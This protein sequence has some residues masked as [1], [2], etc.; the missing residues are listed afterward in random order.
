MYRKILFF[1]LAFVM[2]SV[3][4]FAQEATS[5]E[6]QQEDKYTVN[7][8]MIK[9]VF[10]CRDGLIINYFDRDSS[11]KVLYVPNKFFREKKA[12]RMQENDDTIA[13]QMNVIL[14]N[15]KAYAVKLYLSDKHS[16]S[17]YRYA[18]LVSAEVAEKFNIDELEI[19]L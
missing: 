16:N 7:N 12:F 15:K 10:Q 14:K 3:G 19:D 8:Y 13:P 5:E 18:E 11:V 6:G 4:V 1:V 9:K 2:C 17:V